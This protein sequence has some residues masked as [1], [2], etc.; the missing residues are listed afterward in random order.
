MSVV[1]HLM[2]AVGG[3]L[4]L[5]AVWLAVQSLGRKQSPGTPPP[6]GF[7]CRACA[8]RENCAI[9]PSDCDTSG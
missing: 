4:L 7:G 9:S 8:A 6:S 2:V 5:L 3:I 1:Y